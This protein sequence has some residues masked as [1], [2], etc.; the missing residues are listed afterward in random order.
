MSKK[1]AAK[2]SLIQLPP[3]RA[4]DSGTTV[5]SVQSAVDEFR[6]A[7]PSA[8]SPTPAS[9]PGPAAARPKTAPGSMAVFMGAQSAAIREAEELKGKLKSFDGA[10]PVRALDPKRIRPSRWANRHADGLSNAKF[11]ALRSEIAAAGKNIQPIS[12]R[13][14]TD[15]PLYD[16]ELVYGHRRHRACLDLDIPVLA[17]VSE[18]DDRALYEAMERENRERANLSAWEQG[19]TYRRALDE[20]LYPSQRKLAEAI[21]LDVSLVSK[22]LALARLPDSVV[23]SFASPLDIQ[24][25]WA[26]PLSEALQKDPDG[27]V[28]RAKVVSANRAG[29]SAKQILEAL[30]SSG[31]IVL[32]GSTQ[33]RDL[34]VGKVGEGAVLSTDLS[35]RAVLRFDKGVLSAARQ[36]ALLAWLQSQLSSS[37]SGPAA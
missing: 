7:P 18:M 29:M 33:Q 22:S 12:V 19:M 16:F 28:D 34:R 14:V 27:L 37:E 35:G 36:S 21:G 15:D 5:S 23:G 20:G 24:F 3:M 11:L 25:R 10:L 8:L 30:L 17:V 9:I 2:A 13:P 4:H 6:S 32:N 1:L 31:P 26:Q